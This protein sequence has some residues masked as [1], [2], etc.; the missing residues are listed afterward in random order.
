[1]NLRALGFVGVYVVLLGV[2]TFLE[3]PAMKREDAVQINFLIAIGAAVAAALALL[4]RDPSLPR[5]RSVALALG[6]GVLI[7]GGSVFFFLGL[8][9]LPVAVAATVA[10]AYILVTVLLSVLFLHDHLTLVKWLGIALT[11]AGVTL[12][13]W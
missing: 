2:A 7:G 6:I 8:R 5:A 13:A 10:N 12:L 1:M 4:L 3:K 11:V 9:R